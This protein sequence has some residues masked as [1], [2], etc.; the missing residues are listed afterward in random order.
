MV[1]GPAGAAEIPLEEAWKTL[2]SYQ[3][4]QDLAPLLVIDREVIRAMAARE[5]RSACAARLASLLESADTTPAARQYICQQLRQVGTAAEVPVLARLLG[6]DETS[7]IA[8]HALEAITGPESL[9]A[10]RGALTKV[11]GNL[12]VGVINSLAA[13]RDASAVP[14]LQVLADDQDA[15]VAAAAIWG[16][17]QIATEEAATFLIARAA[18][19]EGPV[20]QGLAVPLLRCA[21]ARAAAGKPEQAQAIYTR[22]SAAGQVPGVRRAALTAQ[23]CS[24]GAPPAEMVLAWL[25][26]EDIDRRLVAA[27]QLATL[28]DVQLDSAANGLGGLPP[29]SQRALM[30]VLALR[31]GRNVLPLALSFARSDQ[32]ALRIAGVRCLGEIGDVS[33][34]PLL[35]DALASDGELAAAAQ[36]SLTALPR[37]EVGTAMLQALATR[38]EIRGGVIEVLKSLRYYEAIDPLVAIAA[39]NDPAEF[40]PA[41]DGLRGI[42]DPDEHDLPRLLRL[43]LGTAPGKHREEVEKTI[44]IVCEKSPDASSRAKPVLAALGKLPKADS[45]TYLPLLGRLGGAEVLAKVEPALQALDPQL[46]DAAVRALCNWPSADV[47]EG[48]LGLATTAENAAHRRMALR[49]YVRVVSLK[50]DRPEQQTLNMLQQAMKLAKAAEDRQLILERAA[51]V[52]TMESVEWIASY[53]ADRTVNQSACQALVEL[54]HHRFLRQPNMDR[55][56][57][58]LDRVSQISENPQVVARAKRYRAGL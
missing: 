42:A 27:S 2:P 46:R 16:L 4:G 54:A 23:L 15:T 38:Q 12:Q 7:E 32:P 33:V 50:S 9:A 35:I 49:A 8:R 1:N 47:S 28:T 57:P 21:E 43:L 36:Q 11:H 41:L 44:L 52:R 17:G 14:Q 5:T 6:K 26:D 20:P 40:G 56:G 19:V 25:A 55:F 3:F 45:A 58:L 53:L 18:Q 13:R 10:L 34:I 39:R 51:T 22:L 48:L 37:Q 30:E 29:A 31:R 24:N